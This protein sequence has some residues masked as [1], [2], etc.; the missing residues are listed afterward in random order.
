MILDTD[1]QTFLIEHHSSDEDAINKHAQVFDFF[2]TGTLT[3]EMTEQEVSHMQDVR[4]L[5]HNFI[6]ISLLLITI[7]GYISYK[8]RPKINFRP[9]IKTV[10]IIGVITAIIPNQLFSL[11]HKIFFPQG[12]YTFPIDSTL[13]S[14]YP[15]SYFFS[16]FFWTIGLTVIIMCVFQIGKE[17]IDE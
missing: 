2:K 17:R 14:L 15:A 11:F 16:L 7:T 10:A 8:K 12:N 13:I 4:T 1:F 5:Y 9:I 6:I 3:L